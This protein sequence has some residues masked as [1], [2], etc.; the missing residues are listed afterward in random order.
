[1]CW[2]WIEGKDEASGN[3]KKKSNIDLVAVDVEEVDNAGNTVT[4]IW[5]ARTLTR[6]DCGSGGVGAGECHRSVSRLS[7]EDLSCS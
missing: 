4:P 7:F 6:I 2:G 1:M 5:W 3:E